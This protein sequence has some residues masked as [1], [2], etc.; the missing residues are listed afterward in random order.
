MNFELDSLGQTGTS[1]VKH[2]CQQEEGAHI[3]RVAFLTNA[4]LCK[5]FG[6]IHFWCLS[7]LFETDFAIRRVQIFRF[8]MIKYRKSRFLIRRENS[9][10]TV[11]S[12]YLHMPK[13]AY[14]MQIVP[15]YRKVYL[16]MPKCAYIMQNVPTYRKGYMHMPKCAYI[17]QIVPTYRKVYLHM[18]KCTYIRQNVPT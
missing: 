6:A 16:H 9:P 17:M 15:T 3:H 2:F 7:K 8:K 12:L 14:I 5:I 13:C 4:R 1:F 18:P 10:L 11:V